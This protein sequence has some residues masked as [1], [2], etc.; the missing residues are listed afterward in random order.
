M[1]K[2]FY[3]NN[4]HICAIISRS[5]FET[6]FDYKPQILGLKI[7]EFSCLVHEVSVK[8][9]TLQYNPQQK[10]VQKCTSWGS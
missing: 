8:S 2:L 5:S 6:A 9:T 10:T 7:E 3:Q 1:N 4:Y